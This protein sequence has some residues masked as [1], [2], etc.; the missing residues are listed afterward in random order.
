MTYLTRLGY[1]L[2]KSSR[3]DI[4][5]AELR[6]FH[7]AYERSTDLPTVFDGFVQ[8]LQDRL[9]LSRVSDTF[10]FKYRY[11][12][13]YF[14]ARHFQRNIAS[15]ETR[16]E[17]VRLS[18]A[19]SEE[20]NAN[21]LL[22][23]AHL[24]DDQIVIE[25]MLAKAAEHFCDCDATMLDSDVRFLTEIGTQDLSFE[26]EDRDYRDARREIAVRRDELSRS[27]EHAVAN[28]AGVSEDQQLV[29]EIVRKLI[30][31][32]KIV[33]ILGQIMKNFPA[34]DAELKERI[35]VSCYQLGFRVLGSCMELLRDGRQEIVA[36][37]VAA[38]REERPDADQANIMRRANSVVF[39]LGL[40]CSYGIVKWISQSVGSPHLVQTYERVADKLPSNAT[41]LTNISIR[42]DQMRGFP[43][44]EL[45][46]L[47][48]DLTDHGL[49]V[50]VLKWLVLTHVNLFPVPFDDRQKVFT[51]LG[52]RYTP[53]IGARLDRRLL[54]P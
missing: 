6:R 39:G 36:F 50:A 13:Y 4:T 43:R 25:Q 38:I 35:A 3:R 40:V 5:E 33:Q 45:L 49:P 44:G 19:L 18:A 22:F 31:S 21:I 23:L 14:V 48:D 1:H 16:D 26:Y 24:T 8:D 53:R 52:I 47:A 10:E 37:A 2:F 12:Y 30:A 42:L 17:I 20:E 41:K 29:P 11:Y 7:A 32:L 15:S 9:I 46:R 34:L 54:A 28:P 27:Q 51:A